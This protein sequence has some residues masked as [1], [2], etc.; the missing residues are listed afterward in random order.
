MAEASAGRKLQARN[1]DGPGLGSN[2]A[3]LKHLSPLW[4]SGSSV[5]SEGC[6]PESSFAAI[7]LAS[8]LRSLRSFKNQ[9]WGQARG[10]VVKFVCSALAA[11][12]FVSL[13]LG[14]GHGTAHQAMLRWRPT[15]HN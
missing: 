11:Q 2:T 10:Q 9:P 7:S 1:A 12:G 5:D 14:H 3:S 8:I 15:C 4:P 13:N 6:S